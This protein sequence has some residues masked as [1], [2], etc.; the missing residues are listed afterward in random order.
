[1]QLVL[2]LLRDP[3][4]AV[5]QPAQ[6]PLDF[7]G[8]LG[9]G[10]PVRLAVVDQTGRMYERVRQ[11]LVREPEAGS[12]SAPAPLD[13]G[14]NPQERAREIVAQAAKL[15]VDLA[16]VTFHVGSQCR[17]PENWRVALEKAGVAA[18]VEGGF[19]AAATAVFGRCACRSSTSACAS[20]PTCS[21][22][23]RPTSSSTA[24]A[25]SRT[26]SFGDA[27]R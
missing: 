9:A 22:S 21:R 27:S 17:N 8:Q 19:S 18:V 13:L 20:T 6:F 16:G 25:K 10:E 4:L 11:T 15:N 7:R 2:T 14:R 26:R 1:M 5:A 23:R 3:H 12:D 24:T